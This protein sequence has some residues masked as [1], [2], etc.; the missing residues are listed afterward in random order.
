MSMTEYR[1]NPILQE[2]LQKLAS[3]EILNQL[4]KDAVVM[5][6]GATGMIGSQIVKALAMHS[7]AGS[8]SYRYRICRHMVC[9]PGVT[10]RN[11]ICM[12]TL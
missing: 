2:D 7:Q 4:E 8:P 12:I 3:A 9:R 10:Y 6:T 5:V 11:V 1:E